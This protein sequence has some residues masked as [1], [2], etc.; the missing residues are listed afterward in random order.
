MDACG[1]VQNVLPF[2]LVRFLQRRDDG[3]LMSETLAIYNRIFSSILQKNQQQNQAGTLLDLVPEH[4]R[5]SVEHALKCLQKK[6]DTMEKNLRHMNRER[7]E[8]MAKLKT[9]EVRKVPPQADFQQPHVHLLLLKL[10]ILK[11]QSDSM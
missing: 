5:S 1:H 9:I 6:M 10:F 2:S 4:E 11:P 8:V 7:E 3:Q